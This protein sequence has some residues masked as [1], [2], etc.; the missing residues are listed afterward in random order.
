MG[1]ES[2]TAWQR[3]ALTVSDM[4]A[5]V[6]KLSLGECVHILLCYKKQADPR[7]IGEVTEKV[8]TDRYKE[9]FLNNLGALHGKA[10]LEDNKW[11]PYP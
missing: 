6:S 10:Y 2:Q 4:T 5:A 7:T 3:G 11:A 8:G 9:E 1:K